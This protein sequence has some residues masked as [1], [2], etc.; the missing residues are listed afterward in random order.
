MI[1][2]DFFLNTAKLGYNELQGPST[3]FVRYNRDIVKN[4]LTCLVK[5][6]NRKGLGSKG[7]IG[8]EKLY[9]YFYSHRFVITIIVL[10]D[11]DYLMKKKQFSKTTFAI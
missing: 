11:F 5:K 7:T 6:R 2:L 4:V 10:T 1:T 8:T 9:K 3:I